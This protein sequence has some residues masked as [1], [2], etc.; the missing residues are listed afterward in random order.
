MIPGQQRAL[1]A[2][3]RTIGAG[4]FLHRILTYERD[5]DEPVFWLDRDWTD[6]DGGARR[7]FSLRVLKQ[8]ADAWAARYCAL[9]VRPRDPVGVYTDTAMDVLVNHL[10]LTGLGAIPILVNGNVEPP[11]TAAYLRHAGAS[12]LITDRAHID[13]AERFSESGLEL[14]FLVTTERLAA[15]P[16]GPLPR[17]YPYRHHDDDPVLV[18]H[19]SGTTGMPKAVLNQHQRYFYGVRYRLRLPPTQ[20]MGDRMLSA[21]PPNHAAAVMAIMIAVAH[22]VPIKL[23]SSQRADV[24]IAEV[25]E[26]QPS[27]V[28]AF[29]GTFAEM[30]A[31]DLSGRG[32]G[33]VQ[34]W[35]STGDAAHES[36]ISKLATTGSHYEIEGGVRTRVP[37]S[38]VVD[39][40][41]STEMGFMHFAKVH[42]PGATVPERCLGRPLNFVDA[43]IL[44]D[45]GDQ[46]PPYR[47]GR[48]GVKSPCVTTAYWN[49]SIRTWRSQQGGYWLTGDFVYRDEEGQFYHLDRVTD[50]IETEGGTLYSVLAE[51]ILLRAL[52][53]IADCSIV[54]VPAAGGRMEAVVC[55]SMRADA[56][57]DSEHWLR[58]ANLALEG[59]SM[60]PLARFLQV[61]LDDIPLGA[62]GKVRKYL[63]RERVEELVSASGGSAT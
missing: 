58:Q 57:V 33:S 22:G 35:W 4:N 36:H 5:L 10:A 54:G 17:W 9:G 11:V 37:G 13:A 28:A 52:P 39:S 42:R 31:Q 3:D 60:P 18:T 55:A 26:F 50:A 23:V 29:S 47:V 7:S 6:C 41:G 24:V 27:L 38:I 30:A 43:V 61:G 34:L 19:S 53:E 48:L 14:R 44:S 46:L 59:H 12:G 21:L 20:G 1:I 45:D 16:E 51:E 2:A 40:L 8:V 49:D 15:V 56:D 62:T 63:L 32:L 25:E